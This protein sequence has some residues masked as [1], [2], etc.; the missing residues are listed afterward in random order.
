MSVCLCASENCL[1]VFV[2]LLRCFLPSF[3]NLSCTESEKQVCWVLLNANKTLY[4]KCLHLRHFEA[5]WCWRDN[6]AKNESFHVMSCLFQTFFL[7]QVF[8][9]FFFCWTLNRRYF[10]ECCSHW[11]ITFIKLI[12]FK[13]FISIIW[14]IPEV[15][16]TVKESIT[17]G[18]LFCTQI[19]L[20]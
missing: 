5:S 16:S 18:K 19:K 4:L 9:F 7:P 20:F 17:L 11:L 15:N 14:H 3:D 2:V 1:R 12:T 8:F 13:P 6:S 10:E